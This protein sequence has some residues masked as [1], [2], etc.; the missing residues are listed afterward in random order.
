M[1]FIPKLAI[2]AAGVVLL[3]VLGYLVWPTPYRYD[4]MGSTVVRINRVTGRAQ[5][6][7]SRGWHDL[8]A[9]GPA[10]P[11]QHDIES[12][13]A[14]DLKRLTAADQATIQDAQNGATFS[15]QHLGV[16]VMR[17][18]NGTDLT[19]TEMDF[20]LT[21]GTI[22]KDVIVNLRDLAPSEVRSVAHEIGLVPST[23]GWA[24]KIVSAKGYRR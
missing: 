24:A 4:H 6:L 13:S 12:L 19:L 3:V 5:A 18:Y 14:D 23:N 8:A 2:W 11:V 10:V 16:L 15:K 1:R 17:V 21:R 7:G 22:S 9:A 20:R